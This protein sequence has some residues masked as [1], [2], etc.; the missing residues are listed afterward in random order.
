[1]MVM[2]THNDTTNEARESSIKM[3][4][5]KN[6]LLSSHDDDNNKLPVFHPPGW[7]AGTSQTDQVLNQL[8]IVIGTS[9]VGLHFAHI[10]LYTR[11]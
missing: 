9:I 3:K 4:E 1:M 2:T 5:Q 11:Q 6:P 10:T 7:K 8:L